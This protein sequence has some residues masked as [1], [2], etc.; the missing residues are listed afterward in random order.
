MDASRRIFHFGRIKPFERAFQQER[1]LV[2]VRNE[3]D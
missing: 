1:F 2:V 3:K